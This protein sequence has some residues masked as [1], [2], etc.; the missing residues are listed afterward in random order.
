[1]KHALPLL[2]VMIIGLLTACSNEV[3]QSQEVIANYPEAITERIEELPEAIRK[4]L[5]VPSKLPES[6]HVIDFGYTSDP[7]NDP[8]GKIILTNFI[9]SGDHAQLLLN[10]MYGD[11]VSYT[12]EKN[13]ETV[14]LDNGIVAKVGD[15]SLRWGN[16]DGSY[17]ELALLFPPDV[18]E[19]EMTIDD[20]IEIANSMD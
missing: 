13:S 14:T 11:S 4:N 20:L 1:M 3:N 9:Y 6:F 5:V 16:E 8:N 15:F 2:V 10:T 12:N 18:T 19:T 17:H 7:P